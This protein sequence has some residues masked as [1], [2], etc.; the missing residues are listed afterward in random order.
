M[1]KERIKALFLEAL[2]LPAA[3]RAA[4]V[5]RSCGCEADSVRELEALLRDHEAAGDFLAEPTGG[6][7]ALGP[8]SAAAVGTEIGPYRLMEKIGEGGFG[9]VYVAALPRARAGVDEGVRA[10]GTQSRPLPG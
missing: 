6:G 10:E 2:E 7:V 5:D 8:D 3:D 4:F 9:V 1:N